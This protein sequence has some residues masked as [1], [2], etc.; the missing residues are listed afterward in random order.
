MVLLTCYPKRPLNKV[1]I[2]W[3]WQ[4][5]LVDDGVFDIP[6]PVSP[7]D[8]GTYYVQILVR[9]DPRSIPYDTDPAGGLPLPGDSFCG[10][11]LVL[12]APEETEGDLG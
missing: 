10:G 8:A 2:V 11:S 3:P 7:V 5:E 1:A 9:G 6:V 12:R 4:M